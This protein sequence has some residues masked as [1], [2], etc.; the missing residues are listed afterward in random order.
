MNGNNTVNENIADNGG[1]R[2]AYRAFERYVQKHGKQQRL[3]HISQYTP[4]QQ[5]F[6]SYSTVS[7]FW[8]FLKPIFN[9]FINFYLK[10]WCSK[11]RTESLKNQ[12]KFDVHSPGR[13]RV[14]V[15]LS[16]FNTFSDAFK[17]SS[18]SRMNRKDKCVL[19]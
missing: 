4:E 2:E 13:Y 18:N 14:N 7:N 12:I 15:P 10:T 17:C 8:Y 3:P 11:F 9:T 16:N 19:W 6:I 5:F 1:I